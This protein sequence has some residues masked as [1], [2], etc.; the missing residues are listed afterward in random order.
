MTIKDV[1]ENPKSFRFKTEAEFITE[2]GTDWKERVQHKWNSD[3]DM[4]YLLGKPYS[5]V[6]TTGW[7][8]SID[9]L[10][11]IGTNPEVLADYRTYGNVLH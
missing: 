11:Q 1:L 8:I 4:D 2:F 6:S 10:T 7:R 5:E 3:G 9:M